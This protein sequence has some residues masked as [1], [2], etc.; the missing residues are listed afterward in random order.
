MQYYSLHK[1]APNVPFSEAVIKGL[2]PDKGLYFPNSIT[3]LP[4]SFFDTIEDLDNVE[5]GFQAIRQ[6]VGDEIPETELRDILTDV[7]SFE[8]PVIDIKENIGTLE[9]FHLRM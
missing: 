2:A 5:I 4:Q 3:P 8:F 1:N 6:F 9:L 7:L